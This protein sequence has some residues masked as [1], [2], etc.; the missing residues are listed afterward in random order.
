MAFVLVIDDDPVVRSYVS[1]LLEAY[2]HSTIL[3]KD[4]NE[5]LAAFESNPIDL[6]ITDIVM[7]GKEGIE[8]IREIRRLDPAVPILAV[9]GSHTEGRYGGY[10]ELA[11]A[12][13]ASAT[14]AKPFTPDQLFAIVNRLLGV[15]PAAAA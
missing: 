1:V 7:P 9:S 14:L 4:G 2:D 6:V 13:G 10:L 3:S 11:E 15:T 5:G 8:T 12:L